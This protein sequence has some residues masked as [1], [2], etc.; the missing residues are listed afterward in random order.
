MGCGN[1]E[2][3]VEPYKHGTVTVYLVSD[4]I[5]KT[6]TESEAPLKGWGQYI[7]LCFEEVGI[8]VDN[9]AEGGRSTKS[10]RN[11][12]NLYCKILDIKNMSE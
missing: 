11:D 4:S 12:G 7:N 1:H 3:V 2:T 8:K 9:R 6:Y 5:Y 10:F